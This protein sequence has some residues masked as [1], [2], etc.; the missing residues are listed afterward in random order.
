MQVEKLGILSR[1]DEKLNYNSNAPRKTGFVYAHT[2]HRGP[3]EPI[4]TE[5]H[6][7]AHIDFPFFKDSQYSVL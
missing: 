6:R 7:V 1:R 3:I 2:S 5:A 4:W